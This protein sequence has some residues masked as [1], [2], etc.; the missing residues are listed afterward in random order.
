ML[1]FL[2]DFVLYKNR[3]HLTCIAHDKV[4]HLPAQGQWFSLGALASSTS[5]NYHR[6]MTEMLLK[7]ALNLYQTI[8]LNLLV[9][10]VPMLWS[11]YI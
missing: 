8:K 7:V 2:P 10:S 5:K 1:E 11:H 3:L 9:N 6:N 4:C